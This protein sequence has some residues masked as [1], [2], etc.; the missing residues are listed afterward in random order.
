MGEAIGSD[1]YL[2]EIAKGSKQAM[3]EAYSDI[4]HTRGQKDK[5]TKDQ[6]YDD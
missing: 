3:F 4:H 2:K 1:K 6:K 5:P